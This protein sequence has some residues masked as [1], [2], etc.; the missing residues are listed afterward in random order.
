[1]VGAGLSLC[2]LFDNCSMSEEAIFS[3]I[4]CGIFSESALVQTRAR[5][6]AAWSPRPCDL[7]HAKPSKTTLNSAK[8]EGSGTGS[9]AW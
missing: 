7:R 4:S 2:G 9:P 1:M 6:H 8:V 5:I 3:E